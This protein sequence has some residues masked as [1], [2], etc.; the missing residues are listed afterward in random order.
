MGNI[1]INAFIKFNIAMN[2]IQMNNVNNVWQEKR[3]TNYK[4]IN[5]NQQKKQKSI[6]TFR[7]VKYYQMME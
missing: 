7:T 3:Y 4:I 1:N 2:I 5:V 6:H